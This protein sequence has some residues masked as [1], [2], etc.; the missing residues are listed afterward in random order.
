M[1]A[2]SGEKFLKSI[3]CYVM[4]ARTYE[5]ALN[6]EEKG[7]GWPYDDKPTLVLTHRELRRNRDSVDSISSDLERLVTHRLRPT[8]HAIWFVGGSF[9]SAECL[10]LGIA[11]ELRHSIVPILIGKGIPFFENFLDVN[12]Y[13]SGVVDLR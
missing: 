12:A 11:D 2:G 3:D 9:V 5:T 8:F 10:R 1:D 13:K 7:L 6:F 4:G